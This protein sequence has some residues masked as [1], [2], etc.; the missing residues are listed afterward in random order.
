[1]KP[2]SGTPPAP[3]FAINVFRMHGSDF[4]VRWVAC[5]VT[6]GIVGRCWFWVCWIHSQ[7]ALGSLVPVRWSWGRWHFGEL[8]RS[9]LMVLL[10]GVLDTLAAGPRLP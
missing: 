3:C 9:G 1:L 6:W 7:L 10:P 4:E 2:Q 8:G 5:G